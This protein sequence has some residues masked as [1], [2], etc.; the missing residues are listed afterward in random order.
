MVDGKTLGFFIVFPQVSEAEDDPTTDTGVRVCEEVG[1]DQ[2]KVAVETSCL[3]VLTV[4]HDDS[5]DKGGERAL[6]SRS[7]GRE[8]REEI[9]LAVLLDEVHLT[10]LVN[11]EDLGPDADEGFLEFRTWALEELEDIRED[12][13]RE[14]LVDCP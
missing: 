2:E 9:D 8:N 12:S 4:A 7:G 3:S 1:G 10:G 5:E 13:N 14:R 6:F 11:G